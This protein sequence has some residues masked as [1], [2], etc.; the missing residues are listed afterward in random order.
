[1]IAV[2]P[3]MSVSSLMRLFERFIPDDAYLDE[4]FI[5][6]VISDGQYG[7]PEGLVYGVPVMRK[8]GEYSVVEG[9]DLVGFQKS[10]LEKMRE[11]LV[12]ERDALS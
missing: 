3:T 8:D 5:D 11:E 10:I 6:S 2:L 4:D 12:G 9:L 7:I 1:M